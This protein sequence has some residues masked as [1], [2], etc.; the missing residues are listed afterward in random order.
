MSVVTSGKTFVS[1][2][3]ITV[4]IAVADLLPISVVHVIAACPSL[5]ALTLPSL[6]TV[7]T[8]ISLVSH[9]TSADAADGMIL[10]FNA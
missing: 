1:V 9:I 5:M 4:T 8:D 7:A 2:V 10:G 6:V 3:F